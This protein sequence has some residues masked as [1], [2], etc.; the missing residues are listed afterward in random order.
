MHKLIRKIM[1]LA[2]ISVS[3]NLFACPGVWGGMAEQFGARFLYFDERQDEEDLSKAVGVLCL[4]SEFVVVAVQHQYW[5]E[6]NWDKRAQEAGLTGKARREARRTFV[7]SLPG[8]YD[9]ALLKKAERLCGMYGKTSI[10]VGTRTGTARE[11]GG[12]SNRFDRQQLFACVNQ[13]V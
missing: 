13:P 12:G 1:L 5:Y 4:T 11:G 7:D 3:P 10:L 8:Q 2:L 9:E 6:S